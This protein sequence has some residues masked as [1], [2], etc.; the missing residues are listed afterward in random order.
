M[1]EETKSKIDMLVA[2]DEPDISQLLVHGL[3]PEGMA[4]RSVANGRRAVFES[5]RQTPSAVLMDIMMSPLSG[6]DALGLFKIIEP[7][8]AVPVIML[9]A[10]NRKEDV[11][12]AM[13]AGA[14]DYITKPLGLKNTAERIHRILAR[15]APAMSPLFENLKYVATSDGE[16]IR[17]CLGGD[18]TADASDDLLVLIRNMSPLFPLIIELD[19]TRVP[20]IKGRIGPPLEMAR[21][22]II[23]AGGE[24]KLTGFDPGRYLPAAIG[25]LKHLFGIEEASTT[26]DAASAE[27]PMRRRYLQ[28]DMTVSDDICCL[29][30]SGEMTGRSKDEM[31]AALK[32]A[33]KAGLPLVIIMNEI[34]EADEKGM[35]HFIRYLTGWKSKCRVSIGI[36]SQNAIVRTQF[37]LAQGYMVGGL[38]RDTFEAAAALKSVPF[39]PT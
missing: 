22:S 7:L 34:H 12:R 1:A 25:T 38:Y 26:G 32:P 5:L 14:A 30:L 10:L 37:Q 2:D 23:R 31:T 36:V 33:E 16:A 28:S 21:D 39:P 11:V 3:T 29:T 15:P 27:A 13:K 17:L 35:T 8:R 6:M 24:L 18:L 9:T 4:V 19:L 20:A